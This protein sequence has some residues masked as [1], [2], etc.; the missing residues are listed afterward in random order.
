MLSK[1]KTLKREKSGE[2]FTPDIGL[3]ADPANLLKNTSKLDKYLCRPG[4]IDEVR[5]TPALWAQVREFNTQL[6]LS[7]VA[8]LTHDASQALA[9]IKAQHYLLKPREQVAILAAIDKSNQLSGFVR[10]SILSIEDH[11]CRHLMLERWMMIAMILHTSGNFFSAQAIYFGLMFPE[12][13]RLFEN[14]E[15]FVG[16]TANAEAVMGMLSRFYG[17]S[18][19]ATSLRS[20]AIINFKGSKLP[21]LDIISKKVQCDFAGRI[22]NLK[23]ACESLEEQIKKSREEFSNQTLTKSATK[24]I[25]RRS[26]VSTTDKSSEELAEKLLTTQANLQ[27]LEEQKE[28]YVL[29]IYAKFYVGLEFDM[30]QNLISSV[31]LGAIRHELVHSQEEVKRLRLL[32]DQY[33]PKRTAIVTH[34]VIALLDDLM[35]P[36]APSYFQG[37]SPLWQFQLIA[38]LKWLLSPEIVDLWGDKLDKHCRMQVDKIHQYAMKCTGNS[39]EIVKK[40]IA[41]IKPDVVASEKT[42]RERKTKVVFFKRLSLSNNPSVNFLLTDVFNALSQGGGLYYRDCM[43]RLDIF[44]CEIRNA[45]QSRVSLRASQ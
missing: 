6:I 40:I 43:Q 26:S 16:L 35:V 31:M 17:V 5:C 11:P 45:Q 1:R 15:T 2:E 3:L 18:A 34:E 37:H 20:E 8:T 10:H 12:V 44:A 23:M 27:T 9:A 32:S 24:N 30:P 42:E 39:D 25:F 33:L 13:S 7:Y 38:K 4:T 19:D 21:T 41:L 29:D 28:Q 36:V 14:E 22:D